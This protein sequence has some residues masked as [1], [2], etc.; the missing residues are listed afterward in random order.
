MKMKQK[1]PK[2]TTII[3]L[4]S[5]LLSASCSVDS[6][7]N[8]TNR[9]TV[10]QD[11]TPQFP[12]MV[13][14]AGRAT[15]LTTTSDS[16]YAL[17]EDTAIVYSGV[18]MAP[19]T[20]QIDPSV[21]YQ[22]MDGFGFAITYA[23]AY[24]LM[25]MSKDKREAF[26]RRTFSP[27]EGYGVSYLRIAIGCTDFS[28][29]EYTLC[30]KEGLENFALQSDETQ[31]IIPIIKEIQAINPNVKVHAAAWKAPKWMQL[32]YDDPV[33]GRLD[34]AHDV[35]FAQYFVKFIQ[36]MQAQGIDIYSVVPISEPL[37]SGDRATYLPWQHEISVVREMA[38]A[39]HE[40]GLKTKIYVYDY[41][42]DYHNV[43]GQEEY[44]LKVYEGLGTDFVGSDLVVGSGWHTY[45]GLPSELDNVNKK[46]PDKEVILTEST[47]GDHDNAAKLSGSLLRYMQLYCFETVSRMCR[48]VI[49]W[50]LMLDS[51]DGPWTP[52]YNYAIGSDK[53]CLGAVDIDV[54]N[55][56]T[57]RYHSNY[58][59][60]CHLSSVIEPGAYRLGTSRTPD[61]LTNFYHM[62][63]ANPDGTYS[64]VMLNY[65]E[66]QQTITLSD[67]SSHVAVKVPGNSIVS[68]RWRN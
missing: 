30:D 29:R 4:A 19:T 11:T 18:S 22:S 41:N 36:T 59:Q 61:N 32:G 10:S 58:F 33:K 26:L 52:G 40:A 63:F 43:A 64:A 62:E 42:Y 24:N 15:V 6:G 12:H 17:R 53:N 8:T 31:Y 51:N 2:V 37:N 1:S 23:T 54:K 27:T 57:I 67:G 55:Y 7:F 56:Q 9:P 16:S 34:P 13:P 65:N 5:L 49:F 60:I 48:A 50:N 38:K 35:D 20:I 21:R 25:Q 3:A 68:V 66:Q 28:S 47:L 39:F 45:G 44:P 14:T 46:A